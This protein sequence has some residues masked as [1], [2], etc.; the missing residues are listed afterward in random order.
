KQIAET[1]IELSK[2]ILK[3]EISKTSQKEIID[4]FLNSKLNKEEI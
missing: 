1:A 3:K 2:K 4:E